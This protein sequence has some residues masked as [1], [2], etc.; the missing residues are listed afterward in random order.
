VGGP[1]VKPVVIGTR[2]STLALVQTDRVSAALRAAHPAIV[3]EVRHISTRGDR[4]TDRPLA[5]LGRNGVFVT[6]IE[7]ALR[8]GEIDLAVHSAKDLPSRLAPDMRLAAFLQREDPRDVLVS[9][10]GPLAALPPGARVGTSSPRRAA[11]LRALRPDLALADVRG[12][13]DTRL[14]RL[15]AGEYSALLLAAAGLIR[16][17]RVAEI[18]EWLEPA[19]MLPAVGQGAL[20]IEVRADDPMLLEL[21]APLHHPPTGFAVGAERAFLAELGGDCAS[22][23]GALATETPAGLHLTAM[24]GAADG[25]LIRGEA[26]G[27]LGDVSIGTLLARRLRR[28]AETST[29]AD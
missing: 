5:E 29:N 24:V 4:I 25:R 17:G 2:A 3:L 26:D 13:V 15:A 27:A 23:T 28:A 22:V 10:A 8:S 9:R 11:Q 7:A 21:S 18:T 12:N 14:R 20:A 19:V 6:E 1:L 16:L